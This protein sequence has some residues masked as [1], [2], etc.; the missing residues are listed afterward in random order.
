V[1]VRSRPFAA[2]V[3]LQGGVA[4]GIYTVPAERTAIVKAYGV[5]NRTGAPLNVMLEVRIA[6]AN[7]V[8]ARL[9]PV[10]ID[11]NLLAPFDEL[12][13]APGDGLVIRLPGSSGTQAVHYFASGSLLFGEPE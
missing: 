10:P 11:G 4:T 3:S 6:G 1:A 12:A 8:V 9:A 5:T 2:G 7:V 13:L